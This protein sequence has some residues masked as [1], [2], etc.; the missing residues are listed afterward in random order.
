[1]VNTKEGKNHMI[2]NYKKWFYDQ[3][4]YVKGSR[5][6]KE[7]FNDTKWLDINT[8][9]KNVELLSQASYQK[10]NIIGNKFGFDKLVELMTMS[11]YSF[12][13]MDKSMIET[14]NNSLNYSMGQMLENSGLIIT[15]KTNYNDAVNE[16]YS[17][18]YMF[19][20]PYDI[21]RFGE[22]DEFIR[23]RLQ[24]MHTTANNRYIPI[25]DF[26]TNHELHRFLNFSLMVTAN[27]MICNDAS[28][29]FDEKGFRIKARW[30]YSP[31]CEFLVYKFDTSD[32]FKIEIPIDKLYDT[33]DYSV[34]GI[35][36]RDC[37]CILDIY[38]SRY[39]KMVNVCGNF[40][41]I[42]IDGLHIDNLQKWTKN[43]FDELG[44]STVTILVYCMS[45]LHEVPNLYPA[46]NYYDLS[47]KQKVFTEVNDLV[48]T[49]DGKR[50]FVSNTSVNN[51]EI[52]TPP[53]VLDRDNTSAFSIIIKAMN[54]KTRMMN[55]E[56][57]L[58]EI[59]RKISQLTEND[60][61]TFV[62]D[63]V[64]PSRKIKES[65]E[66]ILEEYVAAG[67]MTSLIPDNLYGEFE[68]LI[69]NLGKL[70]QPFD[71]YRDV[72]AYTFP[73]LYDDNYARL[74]DRICEPFTSYKEFKTLRKMATLSRNFFK[75]D[76]NINK[77]FRPISDQNFISMKYDNEVGCFTFVN[78]NVKRFNGVGNTFYVDSEL[79]G[80]E[81]FKF[82]IC[83]PDTF[84]PELTTVESFKS[85]IVYDFDKFCDEV[86]KYKGYMKWW[87]VENK[88]LKITSILHSDYSDDKIIDVLSK[89]MK[90]ELSP[91][92]FM[93]KYQSKLNYEPSSVTTLNVDNYDD[94]SPSA[95]FTLNFLFYAYQLVNGDNDKLQSFFYRYLT[96]QKFRRDYFDID[97]TENMK[98]MYGLYVDYTGYTRLDIYN[99]WDADSKLTENG[100]YYGL[101][102]RVDYS[103]G[104]PDLDYDFYYRTFN[105]FTEPNVDKCIMCYSLDGGSLDRSKYIKITPPK[106]QRVS[107]KNDLGLLPLLSQYVSDVEE[108]I[109]TIQT[110]YETSFNIADTINIY[111]DN[112]KKSLGDINDYSKN[113]T[114]AIPDTTNILGS[115]HVDSP[116]NNHFIAKI[117]S[118]LTSYFN[119]NNGLVDFKMTNGIRKNIFSVVTKFTSDLNVIYKNIGFID[120]VNIRVKKLYNH[121]KNFS[122][123]MNLYK[124]NKWFDELDFDLIY[125]LGNLL[126]E[127]EN[128]VEY[129]RNFS[130][131]YNILTIYKTNLGNV[132]ES[133]DS[134][135][136]S[137]RTF[138][139][140]NGLT[141]IKSYMYNLYTNYIFDMYAIDKIEFDSSKTYAKKPIYAT[142]TIS[143]TANDNHFKTPLEESSQAN[144]VLIVKPICDLSGT[145]YKISS[146]SKICEYAIFDGT[147]IEGATLT[148][149]DEDNTEITVSG[150]NT[151]DI[152]FTKVSSTSSN[153]KPL[154]QINDIE[155][156]VV[157]V[158]NNI[159]ESSI[160]NGKV[161]AKRKNTEH[162]EMYSSNH[163]IQLDSYEETIFKDNH[164]RLVDRVRIPSSLINRIR[165]TEIG[166]QD[167]HGFYFKPVQIEHFT[168]DADGY[169]TSVGGN[170]FEGQTLYV[171][172]NDSLMVFPIRVTKV[173]HNEAHG[174]IEAEPIGDT[175]IKIT[176]IETIED[177]L[178]QPI[179]CS[180]LPDNLCNYIDEYTNEARESF[181][182]IPFPSKFEFNSEHIE[183]AWELP[184]DPMYVTSNSDYVFTR[185]N[186]IFND[187]IPNGSIPKEYEQ[188]RFNYITTG[189]LVSGDTLTVHILN[190]NRNN[191]MMDDE[192]FPIFRT[193]PNDH[194]VWAEEQRV[195]KS[196][197]GTLSGEIIET[198][199]EMNV[200]S[201]QIISA[202]TDY[203][204]EE[205]KTKFAT[206]KAKFDKL[207]ADQNRIRS[208][209]ENPEIPTSWH[210]I[211]SYESSL[212]YIS[213]GRVFDNK[214]Y[215]IIDDIRDLLY[216]SELN[217]FLYDWEN[218]RWL[219]PNEYT[220]D[221]T[222]VDSSYDESD[223]YKT[224]DMMHT[225]T[226]S[227]VDT[228]YSS[229]RLF[230]YFAWKKSDVYKSIQLHETT[231]NTLF[232]PMIT[233]QS[234][235]IDYDIM[236]RKNID[237]HE[238][239]TFSSFNAPDYLG[240][241]FNVIRNIDNSSVSSHLRICDIT[242]TNDDIQR[243]FDVY[244]KHNFTDIE[245]TSK[246]P[247]QTF[248]AAIKQ[249]IDSFINGK[250]IKL[251]CVK[252]D[253]S[254]YDGNISSVMFEGH[255]EDDGIV[256]TSS[257]LDITESGV[258]I[259]TVLQ[260]V[261]YIMSGG[262]VN[263]VVNS[264]T[265][266]VANKE[267]I[268]ITDIYHELPSEFVLIPTTLNPAKSTTITLDNS[269][270]KSTT[271]SSNRKPYE[272]YFDTVENIRYPFS[273]V[274]ADDNENRLNI[275]QTLNT[276]VSV[277]KSN[278]ISVCRYSTHKIDPSGVVNL[279]GYIP[280]PLSYDRYEF[281]ING[282]YLT[283]KHIDI[284]SPTSVH[285]HD[286]SSLKNFEVLELVDDYGDSPINI[287][288]NVYIDLDGN[289]YS[290]YFEALK[291][292]SD[293]SS[294]S[295][296]FT[297]N[298]SNHRDIDDYTLKPGNNIDAEP[299]ILDNLTDDEEITD[300][301]QMYNIPTL[302]GM[303]LR[304]L[305]N[306]RLMRE[307]PLSNIAS[308]LDKV[309]KTEQLN[310]PDFPTTHRLSH[311]DDNVTIIVKR[312]PPA[313]KI[314]LIGISK[315]PF[316]VY[317]TNNSNDVISDTENCIKIIPFM[318]TGYTIIL[319]SSYSG[320]WVH[321]T[322]G[323]MTVKI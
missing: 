245:I 35:E 132:Y 4:R 307:I 209:A 21:L 198:N 181:K 278:H 286:V 107:Y 87:Y 276:N 193:E 175:W 269:Y 38:D 111:I 42:D 122:E 240:D 225:I 298:V 82:F 229:K 304:H 74:V 285:I 299:D 80:D 18:Y 55:L 106:Y 49:N 48:R 309:W 53:I 317:I 257:N 212:V 231:F 246:K 170:Y 100:Y 39:S 117:D 283:K 60:Y 311:E 17:A 61:T 222:M 129:D 261:D 180:V 210:N 83:Y 11:N 168:K 171:K 166:L 297:F 204:R 273:N 262:L 56:P 183:N 310:N 153:F 57:G 23:N 126:A 207:S 281:W 296:S 70:F 27:G 6:G 162:F 190:Q 280:T 230:I 120:E 316:S 315:K 109:N 63:I 289:A 215:E 79:R 228:E 301:D 323:E 26:V 214:R 169:I 113:K 221:L 105:D 121:L 182:E 34:L 157:D 173:D 287:T 73:E 294:Q 28:V 218:H 89:M 260:S 25:V 45:N 19:D 30:G 203:E 322:D 186:Q 233:L 279:L 247:T 156:G 40:G 20:I 127:N 59:G 241:G 270:I 236:L 302:N 160:H 144:V 24:Y 119:N 284:L 154:Y 50:V 22:R 46:V 77:I 164:P 250:N 226:I 36:H 52:C 282:R 67:L 213:N 139:K 202:E 146:I 114:F 265:E 320:K 149:Y 271:L 136:K 138:A 206:A 104:N 235:A 288:G 124:L 306:Y 223:N 249:P 155:N 12:Q 37:K 128:V 172:T 14:Y 151:V 108:C 167:D 112:I 224:S 187:F 150:S 219:N 239:Y 131:V 31:D 75:V 292:N 255:T 244:V 165:N 312:D 319:D 103:T 256:I 243:Q 232:K 137:L 161:T 91:D 2:K 93:M 251:I 300:Y 58:L 97:I 78:P 227:F 205:L 308:M 84:N 118:F 85:D 253:I 303:Q 15:K 47:T 51:L 98:K 54:I 69:D 72:E 201:G 116:D 177:Y 88:I 268:H 189:K 125:K 32:T 295:V 145:S 94:M 290:N 208:Y 200:I 65:L 141:A 242:V 10:Y 123:T 33:I 258:F 191:G 237:N 272:F 216:T 13:D 64:K 147:K 135:L 95:P 7:S 254:S 29:A 76:N 267:Y 140:N 275:D 99:R 9:Y 81:I 148:L 68:T 194:H 163:F 211:Y 96:N 252:S 277:C 188:Y 318:R 199:N 71:D 313:Y 234:K 192:K 217:V 178:T 101:P 174:F 8:R 102:F 184:G 110:N 86:D 5:N 195:F 179:E 43:K 264:S 41:H 176:D 16:R 66:N 158:A 197:I 274:R 115:M 314:R 44:T 133:F 263:V 159:E 248:S 321:T 259:C 142:I 143:D 134:N 1:M 185:L 220:I 196:M 293:M 305:T 130:N 266:N 152:T 238:A 3:H 90:R 291:S 92:E 62:F